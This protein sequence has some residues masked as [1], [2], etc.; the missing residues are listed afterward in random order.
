MNLVFGE[1]VI[2]DSDC[3]IAFFGG[4]KRNKLYL[5][6]IFANQGNVLLKK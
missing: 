4:Q 3:E 1:F 2:H 6:K 5:E